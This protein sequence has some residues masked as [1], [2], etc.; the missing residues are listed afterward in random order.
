MLENVTITLT[1]RKT[2]SHLK[3]KMPYQKFLYVVI[4]DSINYDY[5]CV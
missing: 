4:M 5:C 1:E 3:K 2:L